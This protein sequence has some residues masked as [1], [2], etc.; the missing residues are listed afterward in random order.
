MPAAAKDA[1]KFRPTKRM[2]TNAMWKRIEPHLPKKAPSPKGGAPRR[3]DR[4]C[5]E[6]ILWVGRTG[7]PWQK[8]P[9][10][11]PSGSTCWRRLQEWAGEGVFEA[12]QA[13]LVQELAERGRIDFAQLL[14]DAT[15]VRGKKGATRSGSRNAAK[16]R[17]WKSSPTRAACRSD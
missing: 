12:L 14:G 8:V 17:S 5:L 13:T 16:A 10:D 11:L 15:F 9:G 4:D 2:L 1:L 7:A 3:D 6:G